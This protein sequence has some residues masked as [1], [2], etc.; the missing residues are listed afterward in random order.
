M[1]K[2][3]RS[4]IEDVSSQLDPRVP[5]GDV[6]LGRVR[7]RL[8]EQSNLPS[9]LHSSLSHLLTPPWVPLGAKGLERVREREVDCSS[10]PRLRLWERGRG[11]RVWWLPGLQS[12]S[13]LRRVCEVYDLVHHLLTWFWAFS[14]DPRRLD[15]DIMDT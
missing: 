14:F 11:C 12:R 13:S 1:L 4:R 8:A 2:P 15:S 3:C 10:H 7:R 9:T 6:R 5:L